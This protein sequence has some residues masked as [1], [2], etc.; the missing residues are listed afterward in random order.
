MFTPSPP[1][2]LFDPTTQASDGTC[3]EVPGLT[4]SHSTCSLNTVSSHMS[5]LSISPTSLN[6]TWLAKKLRLIAMPS[7]KV[8]C[9]DH[10]IIVHEFIPNT[11]VEG[12][13]AK[14]LWW[15]DEDYIA[16]RYHQASVAAGES[17]WK[18]AKA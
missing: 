9:F 8:V 15:Q 11:E 16:F 7:T 12:V 13:M 17:L 14:D 1:S 5:D 18:G 10:R 3:S 2:L 6:P 4:P